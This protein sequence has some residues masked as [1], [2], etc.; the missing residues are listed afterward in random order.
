MRTDARYQ[1]RLI[2]RPTLEDVVRGANLEALSKDVRCVAVIADR[3]QYYAV[4]DSVADTR[5]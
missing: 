4:I 3:G 2:T 1:Y 5:P